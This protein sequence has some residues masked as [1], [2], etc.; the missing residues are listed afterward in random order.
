MVN[1]KN[2]VEVVCNREKFRNNDAVLIHLYFQVFSSNWFLL[3][4]NH[5]I[6]LVLRKHSHIF[7]VWVFCTCC[8]LLLFHLKRLFYVIEEKDRESATLFC[9]FFSCIATIGFCLLWYTSLAWVIYFRSMLNIII[10][11]NTPS[12]RKTHF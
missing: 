7:I 9:T 1:I 3:I 5:I 10:N 12:F 11:D 4:N 6:W 8:T 2:N